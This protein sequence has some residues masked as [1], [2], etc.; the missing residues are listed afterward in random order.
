MSG[1]HDIDYNYLI[2]HHIQRI[3][4]VCFFGVLQRV[5]I[6]EW[7]SLREV[8]YIFYPKFFYAGFKKNLVVPCIEKTQKRL[9][10]SVCIW[11]YNQNLP[12]NDYDT[13]TLRCLKTAHIVAA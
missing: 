6:C 2:W 8:T 10:Q 7:K 5:A 13:R 1:R 11:Y 4:I 3:P 12:F 9:L